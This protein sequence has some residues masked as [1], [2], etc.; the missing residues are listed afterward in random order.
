MNHRFLKGVA[1]AATV[2]IL[3]TGC[4]SDGTM[5]QTGMGAVIA[6]GARRGQCR[7]R[8]S[9][10]MLATVERTSVGYG[11]AHQSGLN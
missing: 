4:A 7:L 3:V 5:N 1:V 6:R 8:S 2:S 10:P 11:R 9:A